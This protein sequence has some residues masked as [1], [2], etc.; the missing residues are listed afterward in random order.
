MFP[1]NL[2]FIFKYLTRLVIITSTTFI[3]L[4]SFLFPQFVSS[5]ILGTCFSGIIFYGFL[6]SQFRVLVTQKKGLFFVYYVLRIGMYALPL[7]IGLYYKNY[8]NFFVILISLFTYQIHYIL[9]EFVRS[10][11]KYKRQIKDGRFS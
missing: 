11:K 10:Y 4:C 6:Y 3:F 2:R 8:F 7:I 1:R 9:F 5:I